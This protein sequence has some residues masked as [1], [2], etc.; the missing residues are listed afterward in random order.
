MTFPH[1]MSKVERRALS[2]LIDFGKP[3]P[4]QDLHKVS[5]SKGH[6]GHFLDK[7]INLN[8][9]ERDNKGNYTAT[10]DGLNA[11]IAYPAAED[12][13]SV[14]RYIKKQAPF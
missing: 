10:K 14:I 9:V 6:P 3:V 7:L 2:Y 13:W 4:T 11:M 1:P 12:L 5:R 8:Y